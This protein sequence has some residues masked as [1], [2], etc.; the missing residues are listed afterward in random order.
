VVAASVAGGVHD[1]LVGTQPLFHVSPHLHVGVEH[2]PLF[3][4][5]GIACGLLGVVV[6]RG[7]FLVEAAFRRLPVPVFWHPIIGAV[8]FAL[9]GLVVPRALG[10]GY[11][12]ID[13]VLASRL[14]LGTLVVLMLAKLV[15]WWLA[16]GSGTSGG[17]LAPM[18]LIGGAFGATLGV[19]LTDAF[20]GI[21]LTPGVLAL[22][23]MA[24][25]FG[26]ATGAAFTA[27]VFAFELTGAYGTVLPLMLATV[28]AD[29]VF[30]ALL[31]HGLMTEKLARRGVIVPRAY[32]PDVLRATPVR[33]AMTTDVA[34]VGERATTDDARRI[35]AARSHAAY[36]VVADDG[37][38]LGLLRRDALPPPGTDGIDPVTEFA[39]MPTATVSVNDSLERVLEV[40]F[41]GGVDHVPVVDDDE[42]L[43]GICTRT[44]LVRIRSAVRDRDRI[45]PGWLGTRQRAHRRTR[46]TTGHVDDPSGSRESAE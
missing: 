36:P 7:L 40:M 45:Q 33:T 22:V 3:G 35:A 20:P 24:A 26:A 46:A 30:R 29:L 23:A 42:R 25:T 43:V 1:L 18:L 14:A 8:G 44:D 32:E 37:R 9:V 38:C 2:L 41:D 34:T 6:C 4:V 31:D 28:T 39:E 17:T 19:L 12:A 15:A 11:D 5:L 13:D 10:V 27:I 21:G 16:L